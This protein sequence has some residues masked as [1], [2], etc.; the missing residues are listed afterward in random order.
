MFEI[1]QIAI[2]FKSPKLEFVFVEI[3]RAVNRKDFD[4]G[5]FD[6]RDD[7]CAKQAV[8]PDP[9]QEAELLVRVV[10]DNREFK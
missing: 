2:S 1:S 7:N 4:N 3:V 5:S 9:D 8:G 10:R 6:R